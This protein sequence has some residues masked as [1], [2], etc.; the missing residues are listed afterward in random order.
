MTP[1]KKVLSLLNRNERRNAVVLIVLMIIG[2]MLETLSIGLIIPALAIVLQNESG[3]RDHRLQALL[4]FLGNPSQAQLLTGAMFSLV[5]IYT[6]KN[7]YTAFLTWRQ[8]RFTFELQTDLAKRLFTTYL[9]QP[10]SFHLGH[11]SAELIRNVSGEVNLFG[12]VVI[13]AITLATETM[14]LAAIGIL[15]LKIE[16]L[17]T[18]IV[19]LVLGAASLAFNYATRSRI[20]RW[21][22]AR[23]HHATLVAQHLQQGLNGAK[24]IKLLGREK[25]F[26]DR[27]DFHNRESV[28]IGGLQTMM[29][30]FPRLWL[31]ILAVAGMA[32]LVEIM[33]YQGR[34]LAIIVSTLGLFAAAAFRLMPSAMRIISAIQTIKF[35]LPAVDTVYSELQR[36]APID[37]T[38]TTACHFERELRVHEVSYSYP[39][40]AS[41]AVENLSIDVR[42]GECI[43]IIGPSGSGKSTIID[44]VLGLLTPQTG[45]ISVDGQDIQS[46]LRNWQNQIGYVPQSIYLTDDTLRQNVAFGLPDD[47][48]DDSAVSRALDAA[49]LSSFIATLPGGVETIVGERGVRLSG[50][51]RQRIG[52][53]RALYHSPSVLVL[54]EATSALD[55]ETESGVMDAISG[56]RGKTTIII[57]A[58]R[59][60]TVASCDRLYRLEHGTLA[61]AGTPAELGIG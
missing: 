42:K 19:M 9:Q 56:L 10:Y 50:G 61:E 35:N 1:I 43:G 20:H 4:D 36:S 28:R 45:M 6:I 60:T 5:A 27:Y 58:H 32:A 54:D 46:C 33:L 16:L 15:L 24:E 47:Q 49:Q 48:I 57:V 26:V 22:Q 59:L 37:V 14:V 8:T 2:V 29:L 11:N 34:D 51:Q 39:D 25:N 21:G 23:H 17:G 40:S 13:N 30:Q 55:N 31:E 44:L 38:T 53:A 3:P 52:V 41:P 18:L 7:V 12:L